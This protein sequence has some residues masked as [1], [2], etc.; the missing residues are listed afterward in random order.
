MAVFSWIFSTNGG[1]GMS[2]VLIQGVVIR[3]H[4]SI[5]HS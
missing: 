2:L 4:S 3:S 5:H 1:R